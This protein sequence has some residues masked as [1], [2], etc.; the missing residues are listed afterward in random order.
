MNTTLGSLAFSKELHA[1]SEEVNLFLFNKVI[2][3]Y[4]SVK[5]PSEFKNKFLKNVSN[6]DLPS[7]DAVFGSQ[8]HLLNLKKE[9]N[10]LAIFSGKEKLIIKVINLKKREFSFNGVKYVH[11]EKSFKESYKDLLNKLYPRSSNASVKYDFFLPKAQAAGGGKAA[12]A[13]AEAAAPAVKAAAE[14]AAPAAKAAAEAAAEAVKAVT[15][16]WVKTAFVFL[17]L[18]IANNLVGIFSA[19]YGDSTL[20]DLD[21]LVC[22]NVFL[23]LKERGYFDIFKRG[24]CKAYLDSIAKSQV[25]VANPNVVSSAMIEYFAQ[26]FVEETLNCPSAQ[27]PTFSEVVN[28]KTKN[29]RIKI[30]LVTRGDGAT[31]KATLTDPSDDKIVYGTYTF[32]PP[33][34][35]IKSIELFKKKNDVIDPK[36]TSTDLTQ[37]LNPAEANSKVLG[38][39]ALGGID[40]FSND[41]KALWQFHSYL[42]SFS[43][44]GLADCTNRA[45]R[46]AEKEASEKDVAENNPVIDA[47]AIPKAADGKP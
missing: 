29:E 40:A 8:G 16:G 1:S 42:Y 25:S 19:H 41:E 21:I 17:G 6:D 11:Q 9:G 4:A 37:L 43:L 46:A 20:N 5:T 26:N 12:A 22:E 30:S 23:P 32:E 13:A 31:T 39:D 14:A 44:V 47:V 2:L 15:P 28:L 36:T 27:N 38:A 24:K 45:L 33:K 35:G 34:L 7:L 3:N 10:A 18:G